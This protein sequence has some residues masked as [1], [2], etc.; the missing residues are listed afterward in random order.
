MPL[1]KPIR[2]SIIALCFGAVVFFGPM[3]LWMG[4]NLGG[5]L[6]NLALSRRPTEKELVGDYK[7]E[8]SWG[9]VFLH[10]DQAGTF[11]EQIVERDKP[12][13]LIDGHWQSRDGDNCLEL[14]LKPFGM[15]WD[16]DHESQTQGFGTQFY[17]R[18]SGKTYG[19]INDD[20]G[21]QFEQQ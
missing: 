21:E 8:A 11:Q 7:Y 15:V 1:S 2:W 16:E 6:L 14:D 17:K 18:R 5:A 3:M 20:L 9:R 12:A 10:L 19:T 13:R 4:S